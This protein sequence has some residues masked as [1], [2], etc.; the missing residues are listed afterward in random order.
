MDI[1]YKLNRLKAQGQL[2]DYKLRVGNDEED[3]ILTL[4]FPN[5]EILHIKSYSV[6]S[7]NV[8]GTGLGFPNKID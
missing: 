3:D 4:E 2:K 6:D 5:G 7:G 1:N 8:L